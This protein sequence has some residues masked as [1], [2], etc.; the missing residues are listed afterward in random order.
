MELIKIDSSFIGSEAVKT[1]N[2]RDLHAFLEVGKDFSTWIK[3]RI[4]QFGFVENVD[5]VQVPDFIDPQNRGTTK[6]MTYDGVK[7]AKEYALTLDMAKELSMVERNAKGKQ[8]RQ[9]FIECER[10]AKDPGWRRTQE[11][12]IAASGYYIPKNYK[13]ALLFS[14]DLMGQLDDAK[15]KIKEQQKDV[16]TLE[17]IAASEGS[18]C[19]TDTAK[20]LKVQPNVLFN[21]LR[22]NKW[23]YSRPG[24]KTLIA[25]ED[26]RR[27]GLLI[28][29][30]HTVK[31]DYGIDRA[32]SQ[33]RVTPKGLAVL[34]R[35]KS[36]E[37]PIVTAIFGDIYCNP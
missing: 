13:D 10:R 6:S 16:E 21:F 36:L 1:V 11:E 17:R 25:Y 2:A 19:I 34:S 4:A 24:S 37:T 18:F 22:T 7:T 8:A 20:K 23:T 28:H 29:K 30:I 9:Y 15:E 5:Y 33:V 14:A 12:V 31:D 32:Y 27:Q 26:K 3:D 35:Y